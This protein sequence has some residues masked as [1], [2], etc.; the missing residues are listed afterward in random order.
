MHFLYIFNNSCL[1]LAIIKSSGLKKKSYILFIES[2]KCAFKP[3][4]YVTNI[5]ITLSFDRS[6]VEK[7]I[8]G[9]Q[10]QGLITSHER[11]SLKLT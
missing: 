8:C 11:L 1:W 7:A 2:E 9:T 10:K 5:I 3:L 4:I 6:I